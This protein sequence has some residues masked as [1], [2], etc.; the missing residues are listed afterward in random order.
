M[1]SCSFTGHR[2]SRF[3]FRFDETHAACVALKE[4]LAQTIYTLYREEGIHRYY[5]GCAQGAD[6]WA[7]EAVLSLKKQYNDMQLVC[8]VPFEG[9]ERGWEEEQRR[10]YSRLLDNSDQVII[11]APDIGEQPAQ[12]YYLARNRYLVDHANLLFAVYDKAFRRRSGTGYTVR[13][14]EAQGKPVLYLHPDDLH[15]T[16]PSGQEEKS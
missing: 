10:R 12:K 11:L 7:G 8:V 5:T 13:Y 6:L 4:K 3:V 1:E 14:A 16:Y 2:P 15:L 9:Q